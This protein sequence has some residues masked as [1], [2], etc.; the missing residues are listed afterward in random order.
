[1][2]ENDCQPGDIY[3]SHAIWGLIKDE[4]PCEDFVIWK[5][6]TLPFQSSSMDVLVE[7]EK[8][9][10]HDAVDVGDL[11]HGEIAAADSMGAFSVSPC[12]F[13]RPEEDALFSEGLD[14]A[15]LFQGLNILHPEQ[16]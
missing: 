16:R 4:I 10:L 12:M 9:A 11:L 8:S 3:L 6:L 15:G 1:M 13:F 14:D 7:P 2:L 5:P